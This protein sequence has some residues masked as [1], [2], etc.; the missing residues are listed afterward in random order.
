MSEGGARYLGAGD[1]SGLNDAEA[2]LQGDGDLLR[3]GVVQDGDAF[4]DHVQQT[5]LLP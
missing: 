3:E 4:S 5:R 1:V 2:V